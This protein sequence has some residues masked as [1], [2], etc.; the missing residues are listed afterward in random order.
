MESVRQYKYLGVLFS[1]NGSF[2][3]ALTDLYHRG[4]KA[5]FKVRSIF[6]SLSVNIN[7][8]IHYLTIR[9]NLSFYIH[10][11]FGGCLLIIIELHDVSLI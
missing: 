2:T 10:Q 5:F 4:Q 6:S 8:F 9:S 7:Q 1:M 3:N 11:K